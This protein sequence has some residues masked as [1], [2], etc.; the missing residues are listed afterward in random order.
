MKK[1]RKTIAPFVYGIITGI[2]L[3]II[4]NVLG[5]ETTLTQLTILVMVVCIIPSIAI[6]VGRTIAKAELPIIRCEW[7][8]MYRENR[9]EVTVGSTEKLYI[10]DELVDT[11]KG[12]QLKQV[13]LNGKLNTGEE[14]VATIIAGTSVKC[15]LLVGNEELQAIATKG[16]LIG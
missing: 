11:A 5:I 12:V 10:N 14:V 1:F 4:L 16:D 15:Q 2:S 9:I 7:V 6:S 13:S 3:V 8:Y